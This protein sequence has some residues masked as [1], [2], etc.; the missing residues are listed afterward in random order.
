MSE[1]RGLG[2]GKRKED[3]RK[4]NGITILTATFA[5]MMALGGCGDDAGLDAGRSESPFGPSSGDGDGD[6][7]G[8][9]GHE[10]GM[11]SAGSNPDLGT[12]NGDRDSA[13]SG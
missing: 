8:H 9:Q 2:L 10:A 11:D 6:G 7:D 1:S 12:C 3:M 5:G 4:T 13:D